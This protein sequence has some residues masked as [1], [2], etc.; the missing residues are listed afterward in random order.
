[1]EINIIK[2][3]LD[4]LPAFLQA[5]FSWQM[6]IGLLIGMVGGMIV[7]ALPGLGPGTAIPLLLPLTYY[8]DP[9]PALVMLVA[10]YACSITGG[11]YTAILLHT[12]GTTGNVAT[13]FDGYPMAQ[14]GKPLK[15]CTVATYASCFG[16]VVSALALLFIAPVLANVSLLFDSPEYFLLGLFGIALIAG[17]AS[18]SLVKG[19]IGGM[20]GLCLSCI[21]QFPLDSQYRYTFNIPMFR[22][23][24]DS[25]IILLGLFAVSQV[26]K[27]TQKTILVKKKEEQQ[28]EAIK[29]DFK[30]EEKFPFKERIKYFWKNLYYSV[31]GVFIGILP[32]AGGNIGSFVCYS[33]AKRMSKD[34]DQFGKGCV[35]GILASEVGNNAVSG[36]A[37]IPM[38]TLGIP[39]SGTAAL[40]LTALVIQG[41]TPGFSLFTK[42]A[43]VTYPFML[44]FLL[45]NILMYFV[46]MGFIRV[47][48]KIVK[49]PKEL[50]NVIVIVLVVIGGYSLISGIYSTKF[51]LLLFVLGFLGYFF[52]LCKYNSAAITLGL[53]LGSM[54]ENGLRRS[55]LMCRGD[56]LGYFLHRPVCIVL[57]VLIILVL[58]VPVINKA[59]KKK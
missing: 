51:V 36:G 28:A 8:M 7:G 57:A 50:L 39:G 58:F 31:I 2:G 54:T 32:G 13:M 41:F 38:M 55:M 44:G 14:N 26:L 49:I 25:S 6:L 5:L 19:I 34:K 18:D 4:S 37:M 9:I 15:A 20:F 27:L 12:P 48:T 40:L 29:V 21:G 30:H 35:D 42:H 23:G 17:L 24:I 33:E 43:D 11:S 1:M 47:A 59:R 46:G 16:G 56:L 53:V 22:G 3:I 45:V 10:V 52:E